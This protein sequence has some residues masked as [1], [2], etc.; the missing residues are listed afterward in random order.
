MIV[1][2]NERRDEFMDEGLN[3][4]IDVYEQQAFHHG[5]FA[6]KQ[7]HEYAPDTGDPIEDIERVLGDRG[8]PPIM[9]RA[10]VMP[11]R[12]SHPVAYFKTALGLVLLREQIL[13]PKRFD[14]AFRKYIRDWA[15]KHPTPSD[16]FRAMD[17]AGGEDLSWFWR[18]WF[19]ETWNVDLAVRAV[20]YRGDPT[21][22]ATVTI[23]S[24]DRLVL[25]AAVEV[26]FA[27]GGTQR[28]ELPVDAWIRQTTIALPIASTRP[29][30]SVTIDPDHVIPDAD[31]SNNVL[32]GPFAAAPAAPAA[33]AK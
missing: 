27:G 22:G 17:S 13:G 28:V 32:R 2:S 31:R 5:E 14:L 6:P 8:A 16:F 12:Y 15:F 20:A 33:P 1:G 19:F 9:T 24:L 3:T 29:I 10:D 23:A 30:E 26:A 18:G 21:H 25:P 7:D 4:F 11:R